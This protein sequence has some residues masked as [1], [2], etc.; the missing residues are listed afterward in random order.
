MNIEISFI[1]K[2]IA[3]VIGGK[4]MPE[5]PENLDW[6]K[7]YAIT[8]YHNVSNIIG[9]GI[10][11]GA[12]N[13]DENTRQLFMQSVYKSALVDENQKNEFSALFKAFDENKIKYM[14]LKGLVL[15]DIYP[16]GDMRNMS[17]GDIL[18]DLEERDKIEKTM[19]EIGYTFKIE[20]NH[21]LVYKKPPFINVELH[22]CLIPSYNEDLYAYYGDGWK[23]AKKVDN[24][25]RH[26]MSVEDTF[27]YIITHFAKHYRD[28]GAGIKYIIDIWLYKN[29]NNIDMTYVL[30]EMKNLGLERFTE[31][32]IKLADAW[33]SGEEFDDVTIAM[34]N[35]ILNSGQYGNMKNA[36]LSN[37]MRENME[38]SG[39]D[40]KK[41]GMLYLAFPNLEHMRRN[42]PVLKRHPYLIPFLWIW[43]WIRILTGK[44]DRRNLKK[45]EYLSK[46]NITE[47][48]LHM[49]AVGLDIYNG[50]K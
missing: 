34:T 32:I 47:F 18:I 41:K 30:N 20:S 11:L 37:T 33:F 4:E 31:C 6:E 17:D 14:P 7:V 15:K 25:G 2:V 35:Y 44:T 45:L 36:T 1:L 42:Y 39:E 3:A 13:A 49:R 38:T 29:R 10:T 50:R 40:L 19:R 27:I 23:L 48:E 9:Y 26:E 22:K 21:E 8:T 12:F 24:S 28:G 43:R 46:E 5:S 16:S